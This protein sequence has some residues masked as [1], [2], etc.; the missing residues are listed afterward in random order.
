MNRLLVLISLLVVTFLVFGS[1]PTQA[2]CRY[3]ENPKDCDLKILSQ[4]L[5][6]VGFPANP[7]DI[8]GKAFCAGTGD[9]NSW[10]GTA[11]GIEFSTSENRLTVFI[12]LRSQRAYFVAFFDF[13]T[14]TWRGS[15]S[16]AWVSVAG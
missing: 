2:Q 5:T 13:T 15:S 8:I 14:K 6:E 11:I 1:Q 9:G 16:I 4:K 12:D 7:A 3:E 10:C